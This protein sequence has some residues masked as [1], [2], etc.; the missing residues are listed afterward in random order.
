MNQQ[1]KID[2]EIKFKKAMSKRPSKT[3]L[4]KLEA[5]GYLA[6]EKAREANVGEDESLEF[7]YNMVHQSESGENAKK[8]W[9]MVSR[10]FIGGYSS[11]N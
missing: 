11:L 6:G 9:H 7:L 5:I 10:G 8:C 1:L 2:V 4:K 3:R